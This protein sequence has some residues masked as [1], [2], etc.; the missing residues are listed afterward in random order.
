MDIQNRWGDAEDK[1]GSG[2]IGPDG[3]LYPPLKLHK[4]LPLNRN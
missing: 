1:E 2:L 3:H 4:M